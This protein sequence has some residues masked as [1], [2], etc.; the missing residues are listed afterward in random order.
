M[1]AQLTGT[2][3]PEQ[4]ITVVGGVIITGFSDGDSITVKRDEDLYSKRVGTNGDVAR[5]RNP[6]KSGSIE[7]RLLQTSEANDQ[8]SAL[9]AINNLVSDGKIV[10]P[11]AISDLSGRSLYAATQCW[12]KTL[13]EGIFGKEVSERVWV[14]DCADLRV[15]HGGNEV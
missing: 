5:A 8:L 14:F 1:S 3:D 4:L 12:L 10:L 13:P 2:Y 15:Y 9:F 6:N 7:I 11:I